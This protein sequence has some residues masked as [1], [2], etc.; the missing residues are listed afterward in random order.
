MSAITIGGDLIHYEKLGR[1]R[2]V[3][4]M[5]GWIGA[6]IYWIPLMQQLHL[7]YSVYTL[8]LLGFGD[9]AKNPDK[10]SLQAQAEMLDAFMN[11]LGIPK[12]A[13]IGH[14]LGGMVATEF[15]LRHPAKVARMMLSSMPLFDTGDLDSRAPAGQSVRLK[16][17]PMQSPL[18][19]PPS[20][21]PLPRH[22]DDAT[23]MRNPLHD[24]DATIANRSTPD[25]EATRGRFDLDDRQR[26]LDAARVSGVEI[27]QEALAPSPLQDITFAP[28]GNNPLAGI[29]RGRTPLWLLEKCFRRSEP[30]YE[31]LKSHV[32]KSD[33]RALLQSADNFDAGQ[34]LDKL[35]LVEAPLL[36]VH[37][38]EDP[39]IT[40]PAEAVWNYLTLYKDDNRVALPLADV[41][42]FPMLEYDPFARL[43]MDFLNA[44]DIT[45][46]EIRQRWTRRSH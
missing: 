10:Y 22:P 13:I 39:L 5:H 11:Q 7:K 3:I 29:F 40:P 37:G 43:V 12:A 27:P 20:P 21:E 23:L 46:L 44:E 31:K 15:A 41:R 36:I 17:P 8:D 1:G 4:L 35:R 26:L 24:T 38:Q 18:Q 19:P 25:Q 14:S 6:W 45:K 42:H 32:D 2:P 9:S 33:S 28:S 30:E 16:P 34:M